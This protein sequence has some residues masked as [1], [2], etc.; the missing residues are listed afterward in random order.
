[1]QAALDAA[2]ERIAALKQS[3]AAEAVHAGA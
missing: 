2:S 3:H 1:V